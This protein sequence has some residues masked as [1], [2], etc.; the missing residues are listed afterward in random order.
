MKKGQLLAF[1]PWI[2]IFCCFVN[3][4]WFICD[5]AFISFRYV[6]NF[7]DG[8]GLAFNEGEF[9]EGYSNFLWVLELA[10]IW[11]FLGIRPEGASLFLSTMLMILVICG[12]FVV[13]YCGGYDLPN[14][15]A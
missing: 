11:K 7:I 5:D 12:V 14:C 10:A 13:Y 3:Y 9:V 8:Y 6:R 4:S 1:L 2:V 15:K